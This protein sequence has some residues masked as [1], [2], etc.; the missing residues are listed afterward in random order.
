MQVWLRLELQPSNSSNNQGN[1]FFVLVKKTKNILGGRE[2]GGAG[3][4]ALGVQA[5]LGR[6]GI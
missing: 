1:N 3:V 5:L 4:V 6:A 2:V